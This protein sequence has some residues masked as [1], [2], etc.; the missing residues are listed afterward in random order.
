MGFFRYIEWQ[1]KKY[2]VRVRNRIREFSLD[3][4]ILYINKISSV[5]S[6]ILKTANA[7]AAQKY[8]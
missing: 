5:L 7:E 8:Y 1:D 3:R 2:H 4:V 6:K